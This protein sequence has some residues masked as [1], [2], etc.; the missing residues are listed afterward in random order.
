[1]PEVGITSFVRLL[2]VVVLPAPLTPSN[3]K[4]SPLFT[5]NERL[6]TAVNFE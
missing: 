3:A 2:K 4:H 5:P 6:L 1:M